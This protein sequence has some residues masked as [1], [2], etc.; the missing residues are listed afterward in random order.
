MFKSKFFLLN[1]AALVLTSSAISNV[2]NIDTQISSQEVTIYSFKK[3]VVLSQ[4]FDSKD[5][6]NSEIVFKIQGVLEGNFCDFDYPALQAVYN[7]DL[8]NYPNETYNIKVMTFKKPSL[9][10]SLNGSACLA[11]SK[12]SPFQTNLMIKPMG[13]GSDEEASWNY[14]FENKYGASKELVVNL[15]GKSGWKWEFKDL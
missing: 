5:V 4:K 14:R 6:F 2:L 13:W 9:I 3:P 10:L 7:Q 11:Y 15:S 12:S 8:S 1:L